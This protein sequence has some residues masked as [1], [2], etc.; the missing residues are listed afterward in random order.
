ML[1]FGNLEKIQ[2]VLERNTKQK[3]NKI[4]REKFKL[5]LYL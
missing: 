5:Y 4:T 1:L 3:K 2:K